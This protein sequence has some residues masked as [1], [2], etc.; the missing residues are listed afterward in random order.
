M[1]WKPLDLIGNS[2]GNPP[3][4]R[5]RLGQ[6]DCRTEVTFQ[7][8]FDDGAIMRTESRKRRRKPKSRRVNFLNT[9]GITPTEHN[10]PLWP[11]DD[12]KGVG[13]DAKEILNAR[14]MRGNDRN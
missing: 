2:M 7:Q 10:G 6:G 4:I 1:G 12:L 14:P 13:R 8:R 11:P 5:Q 9:V 3:G